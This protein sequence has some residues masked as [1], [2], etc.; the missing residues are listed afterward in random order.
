MATKVFLWL[1]ILSAGIRAQLNAQK[2]DDELNLYQLNT[3]YLEHLIKCGID[4]VRISKGLLPMAN[5]VILQKAASF[6]A[7][8]LDSTKRLTH[9]QNEFAATRTPTL[10][11]AKFGATAHYLVGENVAKTFVD[12]PMKDKKGRLYS[13]Q[14]YAQAAR[15][16]VI[17]WVNSPPHYANI[18]NPEYQ[19]TG[20]A[21]SLNTERKEI[22]AVQKF[23]HVRF[24]YVFPEDQAYFAYSDFTPPPLANSFEGVSR[25]RLKRKFQYGI[26][27]PKDSLKKCAA[28][29]LA[30][31]TA[32]YR[33]E[34]EP[35]GRRLVYTSSN[36]PMVTKLL[37]QRG[38]RL[39]VELVPYTPVDCGNPAYYEKASRR[40]N[41][42]ILNGEVLKPVK[43]KK[44]KEGY[45]GTTFKKAK[46]EGANASGH[47]Q[48]SL[49]S[50]P[51]NLED[52]TECNLLFLKGRKNLCRVMHLKRYPGNAVPLLYDVPY[53]TKIEQY[54]LDMSEKFRNLHFTIPFERGKS[55]FV[56]DDIQPLLDSLHYDGFTILSAE[57][58]TFSSL[59]GDVKV[60]ERL[61]R[62]RAEAIVQVLAQ[63]QGSQ[64]PYTVQSSTN[65]PLFRMQIKEH[66]EL[67]EFADLPDDVVLSR[68]NSDAEKYEPFLAKQRKA[69]VSMRAL[70]KITD[71]NLGGYLLGEFFRCRDSVNFVLQK[72]GFLSSAAKQYI[73]SMAVI[74]GFAYQKICEGKVDTAVLERMELTLHPDFARVI[75]DHFWYTLALSDMKQGDPVWEQRFFHRLNE[76]ERKGISSYEIRFDIVNYMVRNA[77]VGRSR[78]SLSSKSLALVESVRGYHEKTKADMAELLWVNHQMKS[79]YLAA[80]QKRL[81]SAALTELRKTCQDLVEYYR[82]RVVPDSIVVMLSNQFISAKQEDLAYD[83]L[84]PRATLP[85]PDAQILMLYN[86]LIYYHH[87]EYHDETYANWLIGSAEKLSKSAWCSMFVGDD[88]ISF[89]VFDYEP[90]RALYCQLCADYE[91]EAKRLPNANSQP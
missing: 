55:T 63:K 16:L 40:N 62:A 52:Y 75:K 34:M 48:I 37:K 36:I 57:V 80:N 3:R 76:L 12:K 71:K 32:L 8:Y 64:F 28:C 27:A 5:D 30:I 10:R 17:G 15:D 74:Q 54:E 70:V 81:N 66:R 73:D 89:Q 41:Q 2:P 20:V 26:R 23:A 9:F 51:R 60:N 85:V 1:F 68:I 31:D 87:L 39:A 72:A 88:K 50:L 90:L 11:A 78:A 6:H 25:K 65:W 38:A 83:L 91:N 35:D 19:I 22:K 46:K 33:D 82:A 21:I 79:I 86:K 67:E 43:R 61:Q 53:L 77:G 45:R 24:Q 84:F 49:G 47:Y 59:E 13:N 29:N 7:Q 69:M 42:S 14:T 56:L 4:S 44:L 18:I 58:S